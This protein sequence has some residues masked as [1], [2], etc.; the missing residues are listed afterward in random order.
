MEFQVAYLL[1]LITKE[2]Q[3]TL[4]RDFTIVRVSACYFFRSFS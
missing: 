1:L 2:T 3:R 4:N